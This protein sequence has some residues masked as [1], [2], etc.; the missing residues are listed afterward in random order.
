MNLSIVKLIHE[1]H[2]R[3]PAPLSIRLHRVDANYQASCHCLLGACSM[4]MRNLL[5]TNP[6]L[7]TRNLLIGPS[8]VFKGQALCKLP[9]IAGL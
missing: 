1:P 7:L 4:L 5:S 6:A 8:G 3:L 2:K 9:L